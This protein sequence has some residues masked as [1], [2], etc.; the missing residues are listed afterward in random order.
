MNDLAAECTTSARNSI[1]EETLPWVA[2]NAA[3]VSSNRNGQILEHLN[4]RDEMARL[5]R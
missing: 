1:R 2:T 3:A 5:N 4:D